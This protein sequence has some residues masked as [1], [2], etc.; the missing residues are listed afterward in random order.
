[1]VRDAGVMPC[2][3]GVEAK[4]NSPVEESA[5]LQMPIAFDTGIRGSPEGMCLGIGHDDA[6]LEL[7]GE[8]E[9]VMVDPETSRHTPRVV[10]I[11]DRAAS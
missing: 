8:I 1:M 5:E 11:A 10:N 7:L 9:D 2:R 6:L 4:S 3:H